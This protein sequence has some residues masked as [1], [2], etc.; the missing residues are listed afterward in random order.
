MFFEIYKNRS[1]IK[2]GTD[3]I[4]GIDWS[5]SLMDVPSMRL[6][7][8]ITYREYISGR[9][10]VK[11]FVNDKVFWG[12]VLK[13][14]EDKDEETMTLSLEHVIHEWTYRLIS[15]NNAIKDETV[16][17]IFKGSEVDTQGNVSVT[18]NPF[19]M[20]TS[21]KLTAE[22]YISRAGAAAW[23][24]NGDDAPISVDASQVEAEA[25]SYDVI[26]SSGDAAVT[27]KATVKEPSE[28]E[29]SPSDETGDDASVID[30]LSDIYMDT[31]FAYP[32]WI[33]EMDD[34]AKDT[35]ID[36][37]YSKQNKLDALTKTVEL[38]EDLFWRVCFCRNQKVVQ[39][40]TFGE[41]KD[42]IIS[43]KPSG[44]NNIRMVGEP[45]IEHSFEN[46]INLASVYS[47]KSD[48]GMSSMT[49]REVYNDPSLQEEGFPVVILRSNVNNERD[50]RMYSTQ[51]PK[52]APN[53]E[54]EYAVIDLESVALE[55]GEIIEGSYAF[56]D[57]SPFEIEK[58]ED[59]KEK[60]VTDADRI[61]AAVTAYHATIRKLKQNRRRFKI[62]LSVEELPC[63][64]CVGDRLRF[65]YDNSLYI[66]EACSGYMKKV[67]SYNDLFYV[68]EIRY[69]IEEGG[70][71]V[72]EVVLE[73]Y[74]YTDRDIKEE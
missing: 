16:N 1:L 58:D 34:K 70:A 29:D 9:E 17:V 39:I 64:I 60:E 22:Q 37:V 21:E 5:N 19:N 67:L 62:R 3:I 35:V 7:L 54:L 12:I 30:E 8:P 56:N 40:G 63:D 11:V 6:T 32:G 69:G 72:D 57:L 51:Y 41:E 74:L 61:E 45:T 25:G 31:N 18:A 52:L 24:K 38:T 53:N 50:Y 14:T 68:T 28:E 20:L 23:T 59:G 10:E 55:G 2:R 43:T 13:I 65:I 36:Y 48:S 15:V 49:L 47:E 33:V 73:K 46:V 27:V 71:E 4:G 44:V 26:F 42:Y 66:M